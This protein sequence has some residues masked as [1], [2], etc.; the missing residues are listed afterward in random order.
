M[1]SAELSHLK[2]LVVEDNLHFRNLLRS[3]LGALGVPTIEEARDGA[4]AIEVLHSFKADL[5]IVDWKMDGVD[6]IE[7][8]RRI[9]A[10]AADSNRE[11]PMIM[12]TGYT[13]PGLLREAH[14]AGVDDVLP[15]PISAKSLMSRIKSVL[16]KRRTFISSDD[17]YGP[18]RRRAEYAFDGDERRLE[19]INL[20]ALHEN[21]GAGNHA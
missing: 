1:A 18:D 2:V 8:V 7:C 6:G 19:Q 5:A 10:G 3:I 13:E 4:E 15:K 11:L 12:I 14:D 17:Y 21:G 20:V 9:R 16:E